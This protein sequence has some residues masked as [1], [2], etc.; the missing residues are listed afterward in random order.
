MLPTAPW[1]ASPPPRRGILIWGLIVRPTISRCTLSRGNAKIEDFSGPGTLRV[2]LILSENTFSD[3]LMDEEAN[4]KRLASML[5]GESEQAWET[6]PAFMAWLE[7]NFGFVPD[8]DAAASHENA[9]AEHYYTR[10]E[11]ALF[12][13]WVGK[14]WVNPPYSSL[15]HWVDKALLEIRRGEVE[16]IFMLLP[17]RSSTQWFK[18]MFN[19]RKTQVHFITGRFNFLHPD[20]EKRQHSSYEPSMLVQVQLFRHGPRPVRMRYVPLE[21]RGHSQ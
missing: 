12:H 1:G 2:G 16:V 17:V 19:S 18:R 15:D 5:S 10:E 6:P 8:M 9:K 13:P 11:N 7:E 14:V 3:C 20:G 4:K 21:A